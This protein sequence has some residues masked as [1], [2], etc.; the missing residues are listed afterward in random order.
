[1][2]CFRL[3]ESFGIVRMLACAAIGALGLSAW[4][5]VSG[6]IR[7]ELKV[8]GYTSTSTL[9]NFPVLV[10]ISPSTIAEFD[11]NY[12]AADGSDIAFST[13][14]EGEN[15]IPFEIEKWDPKGTSYVWVSLPSM[16][17]NQTFYFHW[18][19]A[20][21]DTT[22]AA[23]EVWTRANYVGVWHMADDSLMQKNSAA[24]GLEAKIADGATVQVVE[25]M[26]GPAINKSATLAADNFVTGGYAENFGYTISS[27]YYLPDAAE[28]C[29]KRPLTF[30]A[31]S[32]VSW[33]AAY[34]SS[35]TSLKLINY[36]T[37]EAT[38]STSMDVSKNWNH[39]VVTRPSNNQFRLILNG[40][41]TPNGAPWQHS[42]TWP[43]A[44]AETTTLN[45]TEG[46]GY[47]DESHV[48]SVVSHEHWITAECQSAKDAAFVTCVKTDVLS[49]DFLI[50]DAVPQQVAAEGVTYGVQKGIQKDETY[51]LTCPNSYVDVAG[52]PTLATVV[53]WKLYRVEDGA[54]LRAS[55]DQGE[56]ANSCTLT[57][58]EGVTLV[59]E[60]D[61][62][63]LY[64]VAPNGN[65][66][67]NTGIDPTS[68]YAT[69]AKAVG[70]AAAGDRVFLA[71]GTYH[72]K[73]V[74]V[75]SAILLCGAT[76][77]RDDVILDGDGSGTVL[78]IS[79]AATVRDLTVTNAARGVSVTNGTL[80]NCVVTS[81]RGTVG[82][83]VS[84]NGAA[85][86]VTDCVIE[87]CVMTSASYG[88]GIDNQKGIVRRCV[89]ANNSTVENGRGFMGVGVCCRGDLSVVE[90]CVITNNTC[91]KAAY[92]NIRG[93]GVGAGVW[94]EKGTV[95]SSLIAH[96]SI[97]G[98]SGSLMADAYCGTA[99]YLSGGSL[100]NCTLADNTA[101]TYPVAA[102]RVDAGTVEN[103]V[104][105]GN[106]NTAT[107]AEKKTDVFTFGKGVWYN[108]IVQGA[109]DI[110]ETSGSGNL[111]PDDAVFKAGTYELAE[112]TTAAGKG[113][114]ETWMADA[115]DLAGRPRLRSGDGEDVV[116]IGCYT[117]VPPPLSAKVEVTGEIVQLGDFSATLTA[118]VDGETDGLTYYWD[119]DGDGIYERRGA[120][121]DTVEVSGIDY[122]A[123]TVSLTVTNGASLGAFSAPVTLK[124]Y[125]VTVHMDVASKNPVW[126]YASQETAAT[127]FADAC[128][129][130]QLADGM[131]VRLAAG[132]N[133]VTSRVLMETRVTIEGAGSD[134]TALDGKYTVNILKLAKAGSCVRGLTFWR[135]R[136][137]GSGENE[138][139]GGVSAQAGTLV[140]D[141]QFVDCFGDGGSDGGS[142]VCNNAT[143]RN[144]V[145]RDALLKRMES[146]GV[147][148]DISHNGLG[149]YMKGANA[150]VERCRFDN[151]RIENMRTVEQQC[152]YSV[153]VYIGG[154]VLRSCL[155]TGCSCSADAGGHASAYSTTGIYQEGGKVVNCTVVGNTANRFCA[156]VRSNAGTVENCIIWDN[157]TGDDDSN[158]V[159]VNG[160]F[161]YC[162]TTP[163]LSDTH[164]TDKDPQFKNPELLDGVISAFS[165]CARTG[166]YDAAALG[167]APLDLYGEKLR[168]PG[169][170]LP[171]G[172]VSVPSPGL[173]LMIR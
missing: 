36:A 157:K 150:L 11:Y 48:R 125:P 42:M 133:T 2:G 4:A 45:F 67:D 19:G 28:A 8:S 140:E 160:D 52:K 38:S 100:V 143:I 10:R 74:T 161:A 88:G 65:D 82:V 51:T 18:Y 113:K 109:K 20:K 24:T 117:W 70:A 158:W 122:G 46:P 156:G 167:D 17:K 104:I 149:V 99:A 9:A 154:G 68:P 14:E 89:I 162:C 170:K 55:T 135:G 80:T 79:G 86:L 108:N 66:D 81:C 72:Q 105:V 110:A 120:D 35:L 116:D 75:S 112:T 44:P 121:L 138:G 21:P 87:K 153:A 49:G 173:I 90:A 39:I 126:P 94:M 78:T 22:L 124:R 172:C 25:G 23:S 50:V 29:T 34:Q 60:W 148:G 83:G 54:L 13:D 129:V 107:K 76:G 111:E 40:V 115:T 128:A 159:G 33:Y 96:N 141:C 85:A 95:R 155:I 56:V 132:T 77:N 136:S 127:N 144:C 84:I 106:T 69:I 27:W 98:Y 12:C 146:R 1:M 73:G 15:A 118:V 57:F 102:L 145:F 93:W 63:N 92:E 91:S 101:T 43:G 123:L 3:K 53:G 32:K 169:G 134:K 61:I 64:Y 168:T 62:A 164:S 5:G 71:K 151:L 119:L 47:V 41:C 26:A 171:M 139:G 166:V 31:E 97:V 137:K 103:C 130:A 30:G 59:W 147:Y 6:N 114:V 7:S 131:T 58:T 163:A 152:H 165:P 37:W 16:A 142:A